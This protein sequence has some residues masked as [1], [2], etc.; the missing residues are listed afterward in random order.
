MNRIEEIINI[1]ASFP[2]VSKD[3]IRDW[4]T[5]ENKKYGY[6]LSYPAENIECNEDEGIDLVPEDQLYCGY[7]NDDGRLYV[8]IKPLKISKNQK[9]IIFNPVIGIGGVKMLVDVKNGDTISAIEEK[10]KDSKNYKDE[11]RYLRNYKQM[12]LDNFNPFV[13][14]HKLIAFS[15]LDVSTTGV[16]VGRPNGS[17]NRSYGRVWFF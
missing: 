11:H 12:Y 1:S 8:S 14:V 13:E 16:M 5:Y 10:L 4:K 3:E 17:A 6:Q 7:I 2:V 9:Q 15:D